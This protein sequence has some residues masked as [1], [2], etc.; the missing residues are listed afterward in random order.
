MPQ[1]TMEGRRYQT[2]SRNTRS[3]VSTVVASCQKSRRGSM[4]YHRPNTWWATGSLPRPILG[5]EELPKQ[6]GQRLGPHTK[7]RPGG[8]RVAAGRA[9]VDDGADGCA[10]YFGVPINLGNSLLHAI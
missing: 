3:T 6:Q 2:V 7:G 9:T 8:D 10:V 1:S 5:H 4:V